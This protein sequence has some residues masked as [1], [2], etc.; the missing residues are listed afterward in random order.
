MSYFES[1]PNTIHDTFKGNSDTIHDTQRIKLTNKQKDIINFCTIPRS[2]REILERLGISYQNKN[3][4]KHI[5]T[6]IDA[7]YLERTIPDR[8]SDKN[9]KYR[10]K[11]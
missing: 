2:S 3:I 4:Q 1:N 9:Q 8:P 5:T 11:Q 7:G 6:L 10:K